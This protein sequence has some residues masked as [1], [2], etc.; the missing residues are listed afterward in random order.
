MINSYHIANAQAG[1]K[2]VEE[3]TEALRLAMVD[4]NI[5]MLNTLADDSLSY[6]HSSG[7]IENKE[8]FIE[9]FRTGQSDFVSIDITD[10]HIQDFG[11]TAI[12]RHILSAVTN[13]NGKPGSVKLHVLLVWHKKNKAWVLVARQ[14]VKVV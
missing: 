12:V 1:F 13:D 6:G 2:K 4:G 8:K 3:A 11:K 14:A 5:Q 9:K 10:Q 7:L